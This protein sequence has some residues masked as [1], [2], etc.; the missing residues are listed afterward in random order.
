MVRCYRARLHIQP[1]WIVGAFFFTSQNLTRGLKGGTHMRI[2]QTSSSRGVSVPPPNATQMRLQ[3]RWIVL[4]RGLWITL[5]VLTLAI[6]FASL[7]V[8]IAQLQ[9]PCAGSACGFQQLAPEQVGTLKGIGLSLGDYTAYTVALTLAT[10]VVCLVVSTVIFLRRSDDRMALLVALML[11][12]FGPF[13]VIEN[14]S[15]SPS[16]WQVPN[17]CLGFLFEALFPLVFSLFPTGQFVPHWTR[18]TI[19]VFLAVNVPFTFFPA[20]NTLNI[21]AVSLAFLVALG[22]L[23]I[24]VVVQLHRY[25]RVS[26]PMERQQTKWV[27]FGFALPIT[28]YVLG[29]VPYLIFSML[30]SPG[31]LYLPAFVVVQDFLLL[32]I[33]F[34]FGFAMLRYRLWEIDALINRTLVY[35]TLTAILTGVYVGMV[36]GLSALLRGIISQDNS[37][38]IVISTLAIYALF[39]PL[40]RRIQRIIDRRF[41]RSKY[42]SAKTVAAFSATLRQEVDLD[43]LREHLLAVVQETMQ[44]A[45]VSLWLRPAEHDGTQRAP[46]RATP[47]V[48]AE[49]L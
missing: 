43:Q 38:A 41:Y 1:A 10:M 31:S 44:P 8:Y 36:I 27:V 47:P 9:T 16:S 13:A 14:V 2:N 5:V 45:H 19:V 24:L 15:A 37:V 34:S 12:T 39:Q 42:D 48:S 33:P 40:R 11:V 7:P 49:G 4:A 21:S 26:S 25:R 17:E 35:G 23:A 18:W 30:A 3:G 20:L 32:L 29:I 28:V 6:V 46:W 22:E